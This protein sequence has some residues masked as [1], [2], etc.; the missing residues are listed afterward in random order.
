MKREHVMVT[1]WDYDWGKGDCGDL[2]QVR[3]INF[4]RR[5]FLLKGGNKIIFVKVTA[6]FKIQGNYITY[7]YTHNPYCLVIDDFLLEE[8]LVV[9]S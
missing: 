1:K 6:V 4:N 3:S 7:C 9:L 5:T 2:T 8:I